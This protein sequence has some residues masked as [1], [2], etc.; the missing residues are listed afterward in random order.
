[1]KF[2]AP[3]KYTSKGAIKFTVFETSKISSC[4]PA[5]FTDSYSSVTDNNEKR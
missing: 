4:W 2:L 1:M 5:K 3:C